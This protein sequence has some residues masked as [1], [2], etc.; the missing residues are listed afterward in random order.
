MS[1]MLSI[2]VSSALLFSARGQLLAGGPPRLCLPL[3]GVTAEKGDDCIRRLAGALGDR[4][5]KVELR[6]NDGQWY[7]ISH[8]RKDV[9]LSE[10]EAALAGSPF[11]VPRDRLRLFGHVQLEVELRSGE[12]AGLIAGLKGLEHVAVDGSKAG[13]GALLVTLDVP[14]PEHAGRTLDLASVPFAKE[15]F[16]RTFG[17]AKGTSPEPPAAAPALPRHSAVRDVVAKHAAVLKDV[18]WSV[19]HG[20][21]MLG[22]IALPEPEPERKPQA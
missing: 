15:T 18:R 9:R 10:V 3:D 6:Q 8:L 13:K 14:Y 4:V 17:S 2:A 12:P 19:S 7:A 20:C 16:R 5:A 11:S 22:C 1:R 21:R